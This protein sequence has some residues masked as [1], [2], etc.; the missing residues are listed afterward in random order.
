MAAHGNSTR[1]R[2][3]R[4]LGV[5]KREDVRLHQSNNGDERRGLI[6]KYLGGRIA[7]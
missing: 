3:K 4:K 7:L 2:P 6:Q 1:G 5:Q